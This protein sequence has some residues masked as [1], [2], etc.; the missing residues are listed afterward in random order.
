M[1]D[2][3]ENVKRPQG[4]TAYIADLSDF[5]PDPENLNLHT[6]RGQAMVTQSQQKWGYAR[7]AFAASDGTVLGGNLSTM[8][9][10]ADIGLG[11]GKVFVVETDGKIPIIHRRTDIESGS[12][13]AVLLAAE[14]NRSSEISIT[15]SAEGLLAK[16]EDG[17]DF[18]GLFYEN[19]FD[20]LVADIRSPDF[21]PVAPDTQPRLDQ[22]S[23]IECPHCGEEF[24]PR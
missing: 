5:K 8:E 13:E 22:K 24:V 16:Q 17:V 14:D 6:Q 7:P 11:E 19:E 21:Q 1:A 9:V 15:W 18:S 3:T 20:D 23:P 12:D 4:P 2:D 10:A